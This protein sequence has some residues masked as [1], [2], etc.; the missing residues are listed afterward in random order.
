MKRILKY[1]LIWIISLIIYAFVTGE[2]IN[3]F[4][5]S[6]ELRF[7]VGFSGGLIYGA[8]I[9]NVLLWKYFSN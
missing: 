6:N 2:I 8:I 1:I 7:I 9:T 4:F 3:F 5:S